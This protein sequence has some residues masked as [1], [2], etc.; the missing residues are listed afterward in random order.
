V[1]ANAICAEKGLDGEVGVVCR[2]EDSFIA[3]GEARRMAIADFGEVVGEKVNGGYAN[4][5]RCAEVEVEFRIGIAD[6]AVR[7]L[8]RRPI[9]E[10]IAI[11]SAG[12]RV[13]SGRSSR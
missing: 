2:G 7:K 12:W 3:I 11:I 1:G 5:N 9:N 10:G 4:G 6:E 8:V 13:G